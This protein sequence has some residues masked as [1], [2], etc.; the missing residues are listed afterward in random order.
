MAQDGGT[1]AGMFHDEMDR[2][3]ES[4]GC[5]TVCN[6]PTKK[7]IAQS[8]RARAGSLAIVDQPQVARTCILRADIVLSFSG[9]TH[10]L[11]CFAFV[12]LPSPKKPRPFVYPTIVCVLFWFLFLPFF[13]SSFFCFFRDVAFS[14]CFLYFYRFALCME[15]RSYV[16][17]IPVG[18]FLPCDHW[19]DCSQPINQIGCKD[20]NL[21]VAFNRVPQWSQQQQ[22]SINNNSSIY[23]V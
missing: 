7:R 2:C 12:F 1:R 19:L 6:S 8:K 13:V 5:T 16:F 15:S 9:V 21:F 18:V 4:Q 22:Q 23:L 11:I 17:P 20:K 14:E 3:R 10:V